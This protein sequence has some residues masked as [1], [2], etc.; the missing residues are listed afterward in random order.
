[1][2]IY[3]LN[4]DTLENVNAKTTLLSS[5]YAHG[6]LEESNGFDLVGLKTDEISE[7]EKRKDGIYCVEFWNND[8]DRR[9]HSYLY[10]WHDKEGRQHGLVCQRS[11]V[12]ANEYARKK[13]DERAMYL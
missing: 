7:F 4:F 12:N 5:V 3:G 13:Y 11:D 9:T 6:W 1:M 8:R 2:N 10:W